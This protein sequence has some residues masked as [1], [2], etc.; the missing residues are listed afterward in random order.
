MTVANRM[1]ILK[2]GVNTNYRGIA[3]AACDWPTA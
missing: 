3:A 1:R 2:K